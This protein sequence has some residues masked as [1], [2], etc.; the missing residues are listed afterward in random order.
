MNIKSMS[1][2]QKLDGQAR[3]SKN[4]WDYTPQFLCIHERTYRSPNT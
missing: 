2:T 3:F 4:R 1:E